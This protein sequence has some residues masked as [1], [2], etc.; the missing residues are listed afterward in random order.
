M[1]DRIYIPSYGRPNKQITWNNLSDK[2]KEKTTIV[3]D[4]SEYN[5]Y[6]SLY[7]SVLSLP[8]GMKGIAPIREWI[9]KQATEEKISMLDDD[10]NFV[11]T[12]REDEDVQKNR[13]CNDDDM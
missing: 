5:E 4:E 9:V 2:W 8:K 7:P 10:L 13:K 12:R 6:S 1:I 3:V 11:Y